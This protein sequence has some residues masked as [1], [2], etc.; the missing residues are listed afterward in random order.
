MGN[1]QIGSVDVAAA[2]RHADVGEFA[3]SP[4]SVTPPRADRRA[5]AGSWGFGED[6][7]AAL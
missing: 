7:R 1:L 5:T 2:G 4:P 6:L 3:A